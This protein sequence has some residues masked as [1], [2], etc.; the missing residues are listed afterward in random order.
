MR[1][2]RRSTF[3]VYGANLFETRERESHFLAS[4]VSGGSLS[5]VE[6]CASRCRTFADGSGL[7]ETRKRSSC[8][9]TFVVSGGSLP[10]MEKRAA[11][12]DLHGWRRL[13]EVQVSLLDPRGQ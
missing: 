11:P 6:K 12:L 10:K 13:Q 1:A 5:E 2:S 9:W 7:F 8:C 3:P 4:V